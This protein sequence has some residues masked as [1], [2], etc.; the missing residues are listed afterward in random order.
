MLYPWTTDDVCGAVRVRVS[1]PA[2][3]N[4]TIYMAVAVKRVNDGSEWLPGMVEEQHPGFRADVLLPSH[5]LE[6]IAYHFNEGGQWSDDV[7]DTGVSWTIESTPEEL[8]TNE[9]GWWLDHYHTKE[10]AS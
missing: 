2:I 3:Q 1:V 8:R 6:L 7:P 9:L 10:N 5:V 4:C